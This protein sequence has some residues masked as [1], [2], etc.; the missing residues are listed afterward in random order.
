LSDPQTRKLVQRFYE[1]LWNRWDD[2]AVEEVLAEGFI[3]R[4]GR[5][6]AYECA[7]FFDVQ[8][9]QLVAA[10]VLGDLA[11]LRRQLVQDE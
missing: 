1:Q 4:T 6:F 7:A 2:E 3:F 11:E 9:G 8:A 10:W 5:P